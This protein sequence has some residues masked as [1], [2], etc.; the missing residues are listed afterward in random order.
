[1]NQYGN[2]YIQSNKKY[3]KYYSL[4]SYE[5]ANTIYQKYL[6][7]VSKDLLPKKEKENLE[8]QKAITTEKIRDITNGA[9]VLCYE[10]FKGGYL[11]GED[12]K[13]QGRGITNQL[14]IFAIGDLVKEISIKD[15]MKRVEMYKIVLNN[16]EKILSEIQNS[17]EMKEKTIKEAICIANILKINQILGEFNSKK[18]TLLR[19]AERCK[20][21]IDVN[22]DREL[23]KTKNWYNEF[24]NLYRLLKQSE[25]KYEDYHK[26]LPEIRSQY[27]D[28]FNEIERQFNKK[29]SNYEFIKFILDKHPYKD[30]E[31]DKSNPILK[32]FSLELVNFLLDKY[33]PDNYSFTGDNTAKLQ[34][35][36]IHEITKKLNNIYTTPQ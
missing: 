5:Q 17:E 22:K 35:C 19:Y 27:S 13:A 10:S 24:D 3:C 4:L 31:K 23:Y 15:I 34:Y 36:I 6:S 29:K 32:S 20:Y 8:K 21:I 14:R 2:E 7:E 9:I 1:M 16:Y 25:P 30:Y 26:I 33:H 12:I 18:R 11:V 28:I